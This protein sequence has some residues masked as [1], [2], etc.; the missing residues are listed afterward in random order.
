MGGTGGVGRSCDRTVEFESNRSRHHALPSCCRHQL[1]GGQL[2]GSLAHRSWAEYL[3]RVQPADVIALFDRGVA[4]FATETGSIESADDDR[5]RAPACGEWNVEEVARHLFAVVTWYHRWLDRAEEGDASPPF[6]L[7]ELEAR[8]A[9][10][11][12]AL[13]DVPGPEAARRFVEE[14]DL[15]ADRLTD[16]FDL[17]YGY[18]F[19]T[20]TAG[21]HAGVAAAEWNLHTWDVARALGRDFEP[22]AP[23]ALFRAAA[24]CVARA[25]GGPAGLALRSMAPVVSWVRPWR[26][27]LTRSGRQP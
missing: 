23:R 5:W 18:P 24:R 16:T 12:E 27:I 15:Y 19:G 1:V 26:Q 17:P 22:E 8:N 7:E 4:A 14:A 11:L 6:P 20:V 25:Q 2:R 9:A 10:E 3:R 21:L 13:A